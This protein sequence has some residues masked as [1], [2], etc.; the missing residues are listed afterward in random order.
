M[1][2]FIPLIVFL[3]FSSQLISQVDCADLVRA[4]DEFTGDTTINTPNSTYGEIFKIINGET[5]KYY[6]H[7]KKNHYD[8]TY[9]G[10]G[11]I[12]IFTDGSKWESHD[13]IYVKPA[14]DHGWRYTT[15]IEL[16]K[17]DLKQF[18]TKPIKKFR[19]Y[20]Y[21]SEIELSEGDKLME[22]TKCLLSSK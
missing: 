5:I 17:D 1:K 13:K 15:L 8:L 11:A 12:V 21:D 20:I 14:V 18:S 9:T 10:S 2:N 19:L 3:I 22:Y 6:L 16:N 4:V 7:L